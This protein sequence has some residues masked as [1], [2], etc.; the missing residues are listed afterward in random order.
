MD[1]A[2]LAGLI[3]CPTCDALHHLADVPVGATARCV[4]CQ[5]VLLAPRRQ[6]L[7]RLVMLAVTALVLMAAAIWF[8][9]LEL[10][11]QGLRRTSSVLDAALAFSNGLMAPLS[12]AVAAMIVVIPLVRLVALI[13]ALA[14]MALGRRPI[15]GAVPAFRLAN[16]MR[17]W[18]MAEIF[19]VGVAIALVKIAGLAQLS[20]G[21]AFWA[22]IALVLVTVLKDVVMC[23]MSVWKTLEQRAA[24]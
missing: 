16:A 18:A 10:D 24:S 21:P 6:A 22:L 13:Y 14:P 17:P 19:V 3:A 7:T 23:R 15:V 4:R 20:L 12:L 2:A 5:T 1:D 9:F 11:A 8:P